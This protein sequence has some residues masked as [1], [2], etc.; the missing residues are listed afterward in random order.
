MNRILRIITDLLVVE[1][2]NS[3]FRLCALA[4]LIE[5]KC[6]A[7][8]SALTELKVVLALIDIVRVCMVTNKV[9]CA[10]ICVNYSMLNSL[11]SPYFLIFVE[12]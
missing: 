3:L 1:I 11:V 4:S 8:T 12:I 2:E 10:T 6:E 9:S 5:K 7:L